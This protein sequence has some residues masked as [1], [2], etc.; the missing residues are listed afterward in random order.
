MPL[1]AAD[2]SVVQSGHGLGEQ[3]LGVGVEGGA[4]WQDGNAEDVMQSSATLTGALETSQ[5]VVKT[6]EVG[7]FV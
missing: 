5:E 3:G 7:H 2:L 6:G 4:R 1:A